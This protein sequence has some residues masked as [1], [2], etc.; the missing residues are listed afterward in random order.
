M[1]FLLVA[2][3]ALLPA[4]ELTSLGCG[5]S[6][7]LSPPKSDN[8]SDDPCDPGGGGSTVGPAP[9]V[10]AGAA[11]VVL[12]DGSPGIGFD[13]LRFSGTLSML[14]VPAGR[15]GDLDLIDPS[16]EAISPVGGFSTSAAYSGDDTFG[17]TSADEGNA[18]VYAVDRTS[19]T[20]AV[21]DPK[22]RAIVAKSTLAAVPGYVRY[23]AATKEVWVTEPSQHQIEV[24]S[25]PANATTAPTHSMVISI[26]AG[27]P[28]SLEIDAAGGRAYTNGTTS[29]IAL[30]VTTHAVAGQW[31]NGCTTSRGIALDTANQWIVPVCEEGLVVVLSTQGATIGTAHTGGGV[32]QVSYDASRQRLYVPG[33]AASSMSVVSLSSMGVPTVLGSIQTTNDAHCAVSAGQGSVYVCAPSLGELLFVTDP[34]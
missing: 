6:G 10:D 13:E 7:S 18:Y 8:Q 12:P 28:E 21:I 1:R 16:S 25:A 20:L 19:S 2:T 14:L 4:V 15:T 17:V 29:T 3:L 30:D 34:F 22:A 23:V 24:L 33:A 5:G 32:D 26:P 9:A 31:P 27:G 11:P